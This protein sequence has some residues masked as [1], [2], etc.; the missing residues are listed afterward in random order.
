[1]YVLEKAIHFNTT[2][3]HNHVLLRISVPVA[4]PIMMDNPE[5]NA[6]AVWVKWY[7]VKDDRETMKGRVRGYTVSINTEYWNVQCI[8]YYYFKCSLV[9]CMGGSREGGGQGVRTPPPLELPD[10]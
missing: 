7:P 5:L 3:K 9:F 6:T 1:M 2:S 10:Y 8:I 4:R